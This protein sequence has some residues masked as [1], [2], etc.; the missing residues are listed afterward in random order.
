[1]A[2]WA[3]CDER[4]SSAPIVATAESLL[5]R[6]CGDLE[7]REDAAF[8]RPLHC[9]G[10]CTADTRKGNTCRL[11]PPTVS[12][13]QREDG[14]AT[15][16]EVE[17]ANRPGTLCE[18]RPDSLSCPPSH[19][20]R[21][22]PAAVPVPAQQCVRRAMASAVSAADKEAGKLGPCGKHSP[23]PSC[24]WMLPQCMSM[25]VLSAVGSPASE[26]QP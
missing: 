26:R 8:A 4:S 24:V 12:V 13:S 19:G 2:V 21:A 25:T 5:G 3:H 9:D 10:A 23:A 16:V 7:I 15:V 18:A 11:E 6:D 1:M 22:E 20:C 14:R 17:S